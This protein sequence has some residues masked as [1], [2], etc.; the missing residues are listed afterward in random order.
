MAI[1][2][3]AITVTGTTGT[4]NAGDSETIYTVP[5]STSARLMQGV[6]NLDAGAG[7]AS[8]EI[9]G[10]NI[11]SLSTN[12]ASP[13]DWTGLFYYLETGDVVSIKSAGAGSIFSYYLS[14]LEQ[15]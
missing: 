15:T 12:G 3:N 14:L 4:L 1:V 10:I 5:A 2:V 9:N 6:Y 13:T 11:G 7:G 8:I